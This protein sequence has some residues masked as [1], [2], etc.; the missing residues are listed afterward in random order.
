MHIIHG[1]IVTEQHLLAWFAN[2][3]R[4]LDLEVR[5]QLA[6]AYTACGYFTTFGNVYP[7]AQAAVESNHFTTEQFMRNRNPAIPTSH[8]FDTYSAGAIAHMAHIAAYVYIDDGLDTFSK[9]F[10]K[11]TPALSQIQKSNLRGSVKDWEDFQGRYNSESSYLK[12]IHYVAQTIL[13]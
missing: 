12:Q 13:G 8:V 2:Y 1:K 11:L 7:L 4:H 9:T 10:I 5:Y 3:A 6:S